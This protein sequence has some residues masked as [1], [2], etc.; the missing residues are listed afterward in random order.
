VATVALGEFGPILRLGLRQILAEA[1]CLV[2]ADGATARE[3]ADLLC[4]SEVDAVLLSLDIAAAATA[5]PAL[6]RR[7]PRT[8]VIEC[9]A[10]RPVMRLRAGGAGAIELA[11][12]V[13]G[14][15]KA[16]SGATSNA[17]Q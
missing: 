5:A 6:A 12:T 7:H 10:D 4:G 14:L 9:S 1:G 15:T 8:R 13:D 16:V 17:W 3:L 11:L 2:L